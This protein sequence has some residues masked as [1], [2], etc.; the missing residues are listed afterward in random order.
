LLDIE[1]I[2]LF[3]GTSR[4]PGAPQAPPA[5]HHVIIWPLR[6]IEESFSMQSD[7]VLTNGMLLLSRVAAGFRD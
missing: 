4:Q 7:S 1:S 3:A 5:H 2:H 6:M